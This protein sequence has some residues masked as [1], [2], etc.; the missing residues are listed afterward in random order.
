MNSSIKT[1]LS[2]IGLFLGGIVLTIFI[3]NYFAVPIKRAANKQPE[4]FS[5]LT[6]IILMMLSFLTSLY[7]SS[8]S[9]ILGDVFVVISFLLGCLFIFFLRREIKQF[10]INPPHKDIER[11]SEINIIEFLRDGISSKDIKQDL[12]NLLQG[13]FQALEK[14]IF[15]SK[16][17]DKVSVG[18]ILFQLKDLGIFN[19]IQIER[20]YKEKFFKYKNTYLDS[21][22]LKA[23]NYQFKK[24]KNNLHKRIDIRSVLN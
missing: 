16:V 21:D 8:I 14:G 23:H 10:I 4:K 1:L 22:D 3:V 9:G 5:K 7:F 12:E 17:W 2:I 13:E 19:D 6:L 24:D 15:I 20:I 11:N 18:G